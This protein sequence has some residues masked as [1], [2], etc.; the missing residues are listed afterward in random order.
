MAL[1]DDDRFIRIR[2]TSLDFDAVG[3]ARAAERN[4]RDEGGAA[5]AGRAL[6]ALKNKSKADWDRL[7]PGEKAI[8]ITQG[9]LITAGA[10]AGVASD[11]AARKAAL[12][13]LDGQEIPVP[14]TDGVLKIVPKTKD[15]GGLIRIDI[16]RL[17]GRK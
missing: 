7:T 13:A 17:L 4:C 14:Y 2:R 11:P 5:D 1:I 10:A 3:A 6:E 8:V 9:A 12:D 15:P 16:I